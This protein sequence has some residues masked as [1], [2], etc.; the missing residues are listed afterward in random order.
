[1]SK[2]VKALFVAGIVVIEEDGVTTITS[3]LEGRT[4]LVIEEIILKAIQRGIN[5]AR[6]KYVDWVRF[7]VNQYQG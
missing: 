3:R 2:S 5:V 7:L 1:M 6:P 4:K